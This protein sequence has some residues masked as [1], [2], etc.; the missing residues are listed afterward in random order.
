MEHY[1]EDLT[2]EFP[3]P[4]LRMPSC[5]FIAGA[6]SSGKST[7]VH[8]LLKYKDYMFREKVTKIMY[9]MSMSQPL[10][11]EI[12]KDVPGIVFKRG[13]PSEEDLEQFTDGRDHTILVLD[14]LLSDI[15][16]NVDFQNIVTRVSH[17]LKITVLILSQNLFPRGTCS[18]TI[19]LNSHYIF[20]L[21]NKRDIKQVSM[22]ASQT[23]LGKLLKFAYQECVL[24]QRYG[25]IL[26][27]LHPADIT[28]LPGGTPRQCAKIFTN[29]FPGENLI[30]Y[31]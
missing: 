20:L 14:D 27:S 12:K 17:H 18:K 21:C 5:S 4:S 22:L 28:Y 2:S 30:S 6:S 9:C 25:Y 23:G 7:L 26:V 11:S 31:V 13:V 16:S 1:V 24:G 29:I 10:Y 19:S 15:V 8:R 3:F